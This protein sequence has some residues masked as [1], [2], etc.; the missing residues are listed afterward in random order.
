M[1]NTHD[2]QITS[3]EFLG[4]PKGLFILFFTEMW[5]RF[6]Y[7]GM[8]AILVLYLVSQTSEGGLGWT[9]L[10]ALKL[11]GWY[12]ML[13][14]LMSVPGGILADRVLGQK[15]CV[16]LGGLL[17]VAG[18]SLMAYTAM[19]A[20]YGALALI[21]LGVGLLKPNISTMVGGLYGEKDDR[22]DSAFTIFY[23]GI[24]I[25]AFL[26]ALIVG[27]VGEKIGWHYGF[28][29]AGIGMFFGQVVF[30]WGQKYLTHVG[31]VEK[32]KLSATGQKE[33]PAPLH[34]IEKDRIKV[35]LISFGIVIVFWAAFEQ[36][37]GFLNLYTDQLTDRHLMGWEVPA[38]W[39]QSLNSLF[40][41]AFGGVVAAIWTWLARRKKEPS[42][43]FKMGLGTAIM[44]IGFL[45]MAGAS[46]ERMGSADGL[47]NMWWVVAAY[48]F[49]TIGEL[50]LS[51]V[52]LAY[53]TKISPKRLVA[54]MMG[55]YFAVTGLANKAAAELGALSEKLGDLRVFLLIAGLS[56]GLGL[57]LLVFTK[58]INR[59]AHE[60]MPLDMSPEA[61]KQTEPEAFRPE[62]AA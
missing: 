58:R 59:M 43:I 29:L 13:V 48:W 26:A 33:K 39:F 9:N 40:I 14:Y 4:H 31:N 27:Y 56:I 47:S 37:G 41:I 54:S 46:L 34:A 19:W 10:E 18:H 42:A 15:K 35:L 22:R 53:I 28:A 6:S 2:T 49:H 7:Y 23:M 25:G 57:L 11:Y 55:I 1:S 38:S 21:V 45:A 3:D 8:R 24:N 60:D 51:P 20:F 32:S 36:A 61:V 17:L 62:G 52:A 16:M 12:T 30:V 50:A 5:E 44:G